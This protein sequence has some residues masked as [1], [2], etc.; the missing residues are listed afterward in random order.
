MQTFGVRSACQKDIQNRLA[1]IERIGSKHFDWFKQ[2][3]TLKS[4]EK[5]FH[6]RWKIARII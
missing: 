4:T 6:T 1:D 2:N 5:S 3:N